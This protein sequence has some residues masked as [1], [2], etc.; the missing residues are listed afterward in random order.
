MRRLFLSLGLAI[1][2]MPNQSAQAAAVLPAS[3]T[4]TTTAPMSL[5]PEAADAL[6]IPPW[7][8][9]CGKLSK[10]IT[11]SAGPAFSSSLS[12]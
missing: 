5:T 2:A 4:G 8:A 1:L 6:R 3:A 10:P 7:D 12:A 9:I 11:H